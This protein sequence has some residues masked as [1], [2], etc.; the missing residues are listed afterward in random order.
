[1]KHLLV[2]R[3]S[4]M[5]DV[6]L[7]LPAVKAAL[8]TYPTLKITFVSHRQF[9]PFF[10]GL[11]RLTYVSADYKSENRGFWG[12]LKLARQLMKLGP[13]DAV[14]DLHSVIRSWLLTSHFSVMGIPVFRIDKGR[15]DKKAITRKEFKIFKRLKPSYERYSDVFRKAGYPILLGKGPWISEKE[16]PLAFF[17][18]KS[19][20]PKNKNWIG[21]APFARH[22]G[23]KWPENKSEQLIKE[24]A[25][26]GNIIFLFGGGIEEKIR[27]DE[28]ADHHL[29]VHSI[30]GRFSLSQ[31]L[32]LMQKVDLMV[33]MDS[34][35]LHMA[36]LVGTPVISI[37][38]PTHSHTG[39]EPLGTN[40]DLK[41]EIDPS[42][43]TC[44]PCSVF[45]NKPC[46]RG[47]YACL[48]WVEVADVK[49]K[50][51]RVIEGRHKT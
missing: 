47:D 17:S 27:L 37:W 34:S 1:M 10:A 39:F 8:N 51:R 25:E 13:F 50:I 45:G 48:N 44:R 9:A 22:E 18:D 28:I 15:K 40:N 26:N 41:V 14:L 38:G 32:A 3:N 19:L 49:D 42:M 16:F 46:F 23:K 20:L 29:N 4:A 11:D 36:S 6:A 2:I 12:I 35:N 30:A 21:I 31:E 7:T 43:L 5:G 24:L 33:T